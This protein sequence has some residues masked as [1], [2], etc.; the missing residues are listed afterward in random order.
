MKN[1]TAKLLR[2]QEQNVESI[3]EIRNRKNSDTFSSFTRVP[4]WIL[5]VRG[6]ELSVLLYLCT[7]LSGKTNVTTFLSY[8]TIASRLGITR[9]CAIQ[10]V[11]KLVESGRIKQIHEQRSNG[12]NGCNRYEICFDMVNGDSLGVVN[13]DSLPSEPEIHHLVNQADSPPSE[14]SSFT[15]YSMLSSS[16]LTNSKLPLCVNDTEQKQETTHTLFPEELEF[17]YSDYLINLSMECWNKHKSAYKDTDEYI[18]LLSRM[19]TEVVCPTVLD[20]AL[21]DYLQHKPGKSSNALWI[22]FSVRNREYKQK[23]QITPPGNYEEICEIV[24]DVPLRIQQKRKQEALQAQQQEEEKLSALYQKFTDLP[25]NDKTVFFQEFNA[26][27]WHYLQGDLRIAEISAAADRYQEQ[28][29]QQ[30]AET[31]MLHLEQ[32]VRDRDQHRFKQLTLSRYRLQ[33][34]ALKRLNPDSPVIIRINELAELAG[35][36]RG[37][38]W[39]EPKWS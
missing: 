12:S 21:T 13:E 34:E 17:L 33:I 31:M 6:T 27:R 38:G 30:E 2:M 25:E 10:N 37:I 24:W 11:K 20:S 39:D 28:A 29:L 7:R 32:A 23:N 22:S 5:E 9:R 4:K 14:P 36:R 1:N 15:T 19:K 16:I 35:F 8:K 26:E 18:E 3:N